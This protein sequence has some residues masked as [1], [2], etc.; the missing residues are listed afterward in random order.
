MKD[1]EKVETEDGLIDVFTFMGWKFDYGNSARD[2]SKCPHCGVSSKRGR[3]ID[4]EDEVDFEYMGEKRLNT[5]YVAHCW[6]CLKCECR[7]WYHL[8]MQ[9]VSDV[10]VTKL[11]KPRGRGR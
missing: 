7:L 5:D 2:Q 9:D 3:A 1:A 10:P 11:N 4:E 8:R 6:K